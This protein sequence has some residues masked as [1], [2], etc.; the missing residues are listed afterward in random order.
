MR[1]EKGQFVKGNKEG[2]QK[3]NKLWEHPNVVK[4]RFPKGQISTPKPFVKDRHLGTKV[5]TTGLE[6]GSGDK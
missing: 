5:C 4:S 1:N 6:R 2:F 3:G